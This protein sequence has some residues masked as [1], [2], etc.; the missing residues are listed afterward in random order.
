MQAVRDMI[1]AIRKQQPTDQ[2]SPRSG[3]DEAGTDKRDRILVR[4]KEVDV[5]VERVAE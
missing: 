1:S 3:T 5:Q 4:S 2:G